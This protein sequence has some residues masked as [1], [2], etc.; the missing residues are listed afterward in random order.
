MGQ[1]YVLN[2]EMIH[3]N[4]SLGGSYQ[5]ISP[6]FDN[7]AQ[8]LNCTKVIRSFF[9]LKLDVNCIFV[10]DRLEHNNRAIS[11]VV[12]GHDPQLM[13]FYR[14]LKLLIDGNRLVRVFST[15]VFTVN[16]DLITRCLDARKPLS[17]ST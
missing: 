8:A 6:F 16:V 12:P 13:E 2:I 5:Q 10:V 3:S 15:E 7:S 1:F 14:A 4:M 9:D 17:K 11:L